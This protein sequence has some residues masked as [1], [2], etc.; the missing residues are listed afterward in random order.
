M[1]L[2]DFQ[3]D[4]QLENLDGWRRDGEHIIREYHFE[5]FKIALAFVNRVADVAEWMNHHPDITL[6]NYN[7]VRL[8]VTTHDAGGLTKKDFDLAKQVSL[9]A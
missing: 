9:L 5:N 2:N 4:Q 6:Y 1:K 7:H 3:I 8:A